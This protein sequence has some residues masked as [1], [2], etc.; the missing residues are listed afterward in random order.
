MKHVPVVKTFKRIKT[1]K[2]PVHITKTIPFEVVKTVKVPVHIPVK[3][4]S[5][6]GGYGG[7]G[8]GDHSIGGGFEDLGGYH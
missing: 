6:G 1:V 2:V 3:V 7:G 8:Y 4:S 5:H